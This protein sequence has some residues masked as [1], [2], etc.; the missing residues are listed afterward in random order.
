MGIV[1]AKNKV[2]DLQKFYQAAY[3]DH[4]RVWKINPRSRWYMIPYVTLLWG[5]LGA[6]FYGM[7]RKVL[8]YN[9]Y[10]GKE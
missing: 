3:K 4:T 2:P 8:G 6:S 1:D 7:G 10:F 9:T 5:S